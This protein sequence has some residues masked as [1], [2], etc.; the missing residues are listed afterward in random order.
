MRQESNAKYSENNSF[1]SNHSKSNSFQKTNTKKDTMF[2]V[3]SGDVP[4]HA[5]VS[6][7]PYSP[8][9]TESFDKS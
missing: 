3:R 8:K 5:I 1:L 4:I 2:S 6:W 9:K 7:V